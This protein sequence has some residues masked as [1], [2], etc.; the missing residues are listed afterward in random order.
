LSIS[1]TDNTE[2]Q[3]VVAGNSFAYTIT[4]QN[5][6]NDTA[7]GASVTDTIPQGLTD[8][9]WTAVASNGSSVAAAS[10]SGDINTL[11]TLAPGGTVTFT[12]QATASADFSGTVNN[13]ASVVA[14]TGFLD[15]N[16]ANNQATDSIVVQGL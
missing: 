14:P 1:K 5:S 8:V 11:V 2:N 7:T 10:G 12:V 3:T 6:G 15:P 4:V 13:T 16:Q 9:T